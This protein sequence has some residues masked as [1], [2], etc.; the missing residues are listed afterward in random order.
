M[1]MQNNQAFLDLELCDV[2]VSTQSDIVQTDIIDL[3]VT[4]TAT[5]GYALVGGTICYTATIENNSDVD[6]ISGDDEMGCITFRDPLAPNLQYVTGTFTYQIGSGVEVP[7]T[8]NINADNVLT[9]NCLEI[10][11]NTTA[12]VK[13]CVKVLS[14]PTTGGGDDNNGDDDE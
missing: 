2:A 1:P 10:P 9:Y 13:F 5:C 14:M 6:F 12:V 4:K 11:A 8:P 3:T 7:A